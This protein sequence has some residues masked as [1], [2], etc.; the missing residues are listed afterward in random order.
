MY[1]SY[2]IGSKI[3]YDFPNSLS[4]GDLLM[5][6]CIKLFNINFLRRN[7]ATSWMADENWLQSLVDVCKIS[8]AASA[9]P[10]I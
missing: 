8:K 6:L 4:Y 7:I 3:V 2:S 1:A 9:L 10:T 5:T